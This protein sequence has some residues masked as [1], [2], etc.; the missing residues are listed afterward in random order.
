MRVDK[1]EIL[2]NL[3]KPDAIARTRTGDDP[4]MSSHVASV[5][6]QVKD[7]KKKLMTLTEKKYTRVGKPLGEERIKILSL[8]DLHVPFENTETIIHA[9]ENHGD[10]DIL[11][12]NGDFL[13]QYAISRWGKSQ[14]LLLEWEYK[15]AIEWMK[16]FTEMF[17]E[18]HLVRGNHDDRLKKY[19]NDSVDPMVNFMIEDDILVKIAEGYDFND[20]GR[21]EQKYDF[22]NV[23]YKPGLLGWITKIGKCIFAHPTGSSGVPM[24]TVIQAATSFM[25]NEN[26]QALVIGHTHKMGKLVWRDKLLIEQG[27]CC[28]PLDYQSDGKMKYLPQAFGYAVVYMDELGN[29]DFDKTNAVYRGTGYPTKSDLG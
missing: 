15:I 6:K 11:V 5:V 8:S 29:V 3:R 14:T 23:Y 10:A 4:V 19:L 17:E 20:E 2:S 12:I 28:V 18:V 27:C 26:F 24:R 21:L 22:S 13:E 25:T 7:L 1:K 16:L 9:L